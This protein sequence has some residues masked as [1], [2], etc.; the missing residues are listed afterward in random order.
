MFG[1]DLK[2]KCLKLQK[3]TKCRNIKLGFYGAS[4]S[5]SVYLHEPN[6][7]NFLYFILVIF[8]KISAN[9]A[10][11]W[12]WKKLHPSLEDPMARG[13]G[14]QVYPLSILTLGTWRGEWLSLRPGCFTPSTHRIACRLGH[15]ASQDVLDKRKICCPCPESKPGLSRL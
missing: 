6:Y 4:F 11:D 9:S 14:I 2:K 10:S 1:N 13:G 5:M 3:N 12:N 8:T 7:A 15:R